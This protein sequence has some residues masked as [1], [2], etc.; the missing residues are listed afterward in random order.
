MHLFTW[1]ELRAL[2]ETQACRIVAASAS[3][4]LSLQNDAVAEDWL[5]DEDMSRVLLD[6]EARACADPAVV[7]AGTHIIA[8]VERLQPTSSFP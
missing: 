5:A 2:L 6:W 3:N 7:G 1:E 8:V 4:F